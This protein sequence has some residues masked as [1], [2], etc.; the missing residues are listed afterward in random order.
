MLS[1]NGEADSSLHRRK[2][3]SQLNYDDKVAY[4]SGMAEERSTKEHIVG[5]MS[6]DLT[7]MRS[8]RLFYSDE[9]ETCG[10]LVLASCECQYKIFHF[11]NGGQLKS[12]RY[13]RTRMKETFGYKKRFHSSAFMQ[14]NLSMLIGQLIKNFSHRSLSFFYPSLTVFNRTGLV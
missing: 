13:S 4:S 3:L 5:V 12:S 2:I 10:Q 1:R 7:Q 8:I 6:A 14:D 11:H 9:R